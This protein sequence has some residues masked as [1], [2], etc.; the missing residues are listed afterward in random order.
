MIQVK[1]VQRKAVRMKKQHTQMKLGML[2]M[3]YQDALQSPKHK[4]NGY[5]PQLMNMLHCDILFLY[6]GELIKI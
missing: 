2:L 1:D 3:C 4:K 6:V 5:F